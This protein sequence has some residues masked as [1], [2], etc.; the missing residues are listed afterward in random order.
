MRIDVN[1]IQRDI[2]AI[3]TFTATPGA[4]ATRLS[5]SE[6]YGKACDYVADAARGL[7]MT[8]R[9]DAV[10]NLR[11]RLP[12]RSPDKPAVLIASHLDSVRNGGNFD[13]VLGIVCGLE[14]VRAIVESGERLDRDIEILSFVEEEGTSFRCPLAGSKAVTGLLDLKDLEAVRND[15]G[16]SFLSAARDFGL[17][18][19]RLPEDILLPERVHV[20]FELHIEQGQ[21]LES[22]RLAIGIVDCIAGSDNLR[23]RL[24]GLANHAGATPMR[25]RQDALAG[26]AEVVIAVERIATSPRRPNAVA[27]VGRIV[28]EP[29]SANVI[30]G[31]VEFSIDIRDTDAAAISN[32]SAAI[33]EAVSAISEAR[34]LGSDIALTGRSSPVRLSAGTASRLEAIA[35]RGG[36]A[37][38]RM[39]SGALHDAA[40]MGR[41]ADVGLIFVPS[42]NGRSHCPEEFTACSDIEPGAELLARAVHAYATS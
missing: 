40:M 42:R 19:H 30:P 38:R 23:V 22:E 15:K 1:R 11:M 31:A 39:Q 4:G 8:A 29:N 14:A 9:Y 5:F 16:E 12:G 35:L 25:L 7:G 37:F 34:R 27:T 13:G 17:E 10:G 3:A 6:E 26:A 20:A 33:G 41:V 18:P 2:E 21:I 36:Q 32:A 28:C 24:T